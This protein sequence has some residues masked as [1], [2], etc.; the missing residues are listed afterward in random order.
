MTRKIAIGKTY[1]SQG[2]QTGPSYKHLRSV[3]VLP[4]CARP[5]FAA[6]PSPEAGGTP[7]GDAFSQSKILPTE[8]DISK[9]AANRDAIAAG[10]FP[11]ERCLAW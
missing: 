8:P 1:E 11:A 5:R 7:A 2:R 6:R 3:S 4:V 10:S 9:S